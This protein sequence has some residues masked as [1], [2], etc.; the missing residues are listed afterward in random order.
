MDI[1]ND[2]ILDLFLCL[3]HGELAYYKGT[4]PGSTDLNPKTSIYTTPGMGKYLP[5]YPHDWDGDGLTDILVLEATFKIFKNTGTLSNPAFD[6]ATPIPVSCIDENGEEGSWS[7]S[8]YGRESF[9][10]AD[11]NRDGLVDLV[12]VDECFADEEAPGGGSLFTSQIDIYYNI[13]T[14]EM[15]AF[16]YA[17]NLHN[18]AD[19]PLGEATRVT[20]V[21]IN[22]DGAIDVIGSETMTLGDVSEERRWSL[23]IW[24]GIPD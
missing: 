3:P 15:P 6:T 19:T 5:F 18:S 1:D 2:G 11:I 7:Q 13:G 20:L 22:D 23:V 12:I 9:N 8:T 10:A 21:D 4:A 14:N 24:K 16:K 17:F